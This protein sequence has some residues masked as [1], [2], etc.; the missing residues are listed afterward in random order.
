MSKKEANS[1]TTDKEPQTSRDDF[2][3]IRDVGID[4]LKQFLIQT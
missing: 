1:T 3:K 2:T 4:F